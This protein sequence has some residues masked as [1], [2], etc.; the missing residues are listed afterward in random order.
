MEEVD[1]VVSWEEARLVEPS[2]WGILRFSE[3]TWTGTPSEELP[4]LRLDDVCEQD[5]MEVK[6]MNK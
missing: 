2:S 4:D 6:P 1:V 5:A 3:A